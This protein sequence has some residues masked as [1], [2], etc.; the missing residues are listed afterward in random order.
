MRL[1]LKIIAPLVLAFSAATAA[2]QEFPSKPIRI[3]VPYAP[4]GATD[5]LA[6]KLGNDL[7]Q[8]LKQSVV[9]ENRPG[10]NT[11]I[12]AQALAAAEPDGYTVAIFSNS[13][14]TMNP[15]LYKKLGYDPQK[16]FQPVIRLTRIPLAIVANPSFPA[17]DVQGL[18]QYAKAH[19]GLP[20]GTPST[21]DPNHLA[22][23][24]LAK[25]GSVELTQVAYKGSAPAAQ[26]V[27]A[28]QVPIALLD[29]AS[30]IQFIKGGRMKVLA[31]T[32]Q[33]RS[34]LLPGVKTV[35]ESG[36]PGFQAES[37]FGAF[38]PRGTAPAIVAQ[39]NAALRESLDSPE[40]KAWL[41]LQ[42]LIAAPTTPDE[43]RELIAQESDKYAKLI[44]QA[45]L[46]LD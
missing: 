26:D 33:T 11:V 34:P 35:A 39:L 25:Q 9:V 17:N 8:R 42:F 18:V 27:V 22:M 6:R 32:G 45:G 24:Q 14:V 40:V 12:A 31:L 38:V 46:T 2:A 16:S 15:Y 23:V 28:G 1:S 41:E 19:P 13:T 5:N 36:Y 29:I 21:G 44:Q 7:S 37:W 43:Y 30:G 3:I 10:G 4:G 20:Y